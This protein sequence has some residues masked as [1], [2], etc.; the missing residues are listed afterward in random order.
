LV[1]LIHYQTPYL[2]PT[3]GEKFMPQMR[4][5]NLLIGSI[6]LIFAVIACGPSV[7]SGLPT[8]NGTSGTGG[9]PTGS[10]SSN[11]STVKPNPVTVTAV[12]DTARAISNADS[13]D[14]GIG[15]GFLKD[16]K[17][18]DGTPFS[19][20]LTGAMFKPDAAG[21]LSL[22]LGTAVTATP[23]SSIKD[24]PFSK[25]Y[26]A[27]VHIGPDGLLLEMP[28]T[29]TITLQGIY[30]VSTLIGFAADGTG[31]D[32][33]LFPVTVYADAS[34][35]T[36]TVYFSIEHFS[37]YGVAQVTAQEIQAQL[38]HPPVNP[39]SQDEEE[40]APLTP[41]L[42]DESLAPLPSKIQ[43]KLGKSYNQL[44]KPYLSNLADVPCNRVDVAAYQFNAWQAKV[45]MTSQ[46]DFYQEQITKDA[47]NLL[48]RLTECARVA[49]DS[50]INNTSGAKLDSASINHLLVLAAFAGD[51]ASLLG[52]TDESSY[53]MQLS[54][55]CADD[56]GYPPLYFRS[57]GDCMGVCVT[58]VP[59]VCK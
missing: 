17:T 33:H 56:A 42:S 47:T 11:N 34:S 53:W 54:S 28:G 3:T 7:K 4:L 40:L 44:V 16:G 35:G 48:T 19:L 49:C 22:V 45:D 18:A 46:T 27:A 26:L 36:T 6:A 21:D 8:G 55:K 5:R 9:L 59:L 37:L 15:T 51:M 10:G 24:I 13:L 29:L 38:G 20:M 50:C 1:Y 39:A 32:F 30:D 57:Y 14:P 23:I 12:L 25:G 2:E 31:A 58:S 52:N 41:I 43:L